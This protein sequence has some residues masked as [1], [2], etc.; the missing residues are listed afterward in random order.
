M[1]R[2]LIAAAVMA[3]CLALVAVLLFADPSLAGPLK[4]IGENTKTE[5]SGA[6]K[7]LFGL[8]L[9]VLFVILWWQ[10][11]YPAMVIALLV[12]AIPAYMIYIPDGGGTMLKSIADSIF[13]K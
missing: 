6:L 12:A 3:S 1:N 11:M 7:P 5:V 10:R 8:A 9:A 13:P 4:Q 2:S